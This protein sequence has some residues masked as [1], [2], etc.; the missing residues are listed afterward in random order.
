ML[1]N[2]PGFRAGNLGVPSPG[3][4]HLREP[5][6]ARQSKTTATAPYG[7]GTRMNTRGDT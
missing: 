1:P 6:I 5:S 3:F 7:S 4:G 2:W